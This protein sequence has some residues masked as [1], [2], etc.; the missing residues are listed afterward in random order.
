MNASAKHLLDWPKSLSN[1]NTRSPNDFSNS[2]CERCWYSLS[3]KNFID[4]R[5]CLALERSSRSYE[6][7]SMSHSPNCES[8]CANIRVCRL[9][10][11]LDLHDMNSPRLTFSHRDLP[12]KQSSYDSTRQFF[13]CRIHVAPRLTCCHSLIY[14]FIQIDILRVLI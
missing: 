11:R 8:Y 10:A 6:S 3:A 5:V 7:L 1:L 13:E 2:N 9:E 14:L 4:D 12:L